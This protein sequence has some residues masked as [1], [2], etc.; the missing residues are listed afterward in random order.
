MLWASTA[1]SAVDLHPSLGFDISYAQG[2]SGTS[3]VG[4]GRHSTTAIN[5]HA[6][7]WAG[8]AASAVD[9][10]PALLGSASFSYGLGIS[11]VNQV[12]YGR[13]SATSGN[14]HAILWSGTAASAVDLHSFLTGLSVTL[15][16]SFAT[17]IDSNGD[18]VGYGV[19]DDFNFYALL[20]STD[21]QQNGGGGGGAVPEPGSAALL[22]LGLALNR[23]RHRLSHRRCAAND[24]AFC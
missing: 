8:S 23:F 21:S 17:A 6:L 16:G 11:G 19:D 10:H 2:V 7:L 12:G 15:V 18:I 1:A 20:W 9:L 4:F 5:D 14:N 22:A 3:Q 13:G 24:K